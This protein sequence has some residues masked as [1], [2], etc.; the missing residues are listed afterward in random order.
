M[1]KYNIDFANGSIYKIVCNDLTITDIYVGSTTNLNERK[2]HHKGSC[3]NPNQKNYNSPCYVFIRDNGGWNNFN[4][5]LI[6]HYPCKDKF[7]LL[8]RE[9][10]WI[11]I[12]KASLNH[13]I[14]TRTPKERYEENKEELNEDCKI[15]RQ[16]NPDKVKDQWANYYEQHKDELN[17]KKNQKFDCECKGKY[18]LRCKARHARS[19]KHLKYLENEIASDSD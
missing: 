6:E 10:H 12:L 16:N 11:E 8:A 19:K 9:R 4:L 13:S 2:K 15:W 3:N 14:P 7:E 17:E 5:I 1:P 18:T